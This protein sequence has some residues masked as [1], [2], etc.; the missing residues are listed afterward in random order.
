M[1][2]VHVPAT[3]ANVGAGF[4]AVGLALGLGNTVVMEEMDGC[5]IAPLD[6][7]PVPQ[8]EDNLVYSS[9]KLLYSHCGKVFTG[10]RLRQTSPVPTTR[11]MGS[12]SACIVAGLIGANALMIN[13]CTREELLT[14]AAGIEGHPDNVAP[15]MLGG[16]VASCL[17]DGQVYSVKKELSPVLEFAAFIPDYELSTQKARD[18]L[19]QTV[20]LA[21]AVHNLSRAPLLQAAL[22]EGRLDLLEVATSDAL[23]QQYRLPLMP[24]G[25]EVF[26]LARGAGAPA[27]F[28]SGAGPTVVAVVESSRTDFW[29]KAADALHQAA[30]EN[31]PAARFSMQRLKGDNMGAR[32]I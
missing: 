19:P 29:Q 8:G 23:H 18:A 27:V 1:I 2:S 30:H 10:L 31:S 16:L 28:I 22:C 12:S 26:A 32:L 6:G 4:D 5:D 25:K 20:T 7:T 24:G 3:S 17:Q 21:S 15:A 11:G 14:I 13:P 9:A